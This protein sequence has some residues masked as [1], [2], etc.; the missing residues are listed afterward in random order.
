MLQLEVGPSHFALY[1]LLFSSLGPYNLNI[2]F[3]HSTVAH[4]HSLDL[5]M[6]FLSQTYRVLEAEVNQLASHGIAANFIF[7]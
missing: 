4:S 6:W 1:L 3:S 7:A 2:S 5:R